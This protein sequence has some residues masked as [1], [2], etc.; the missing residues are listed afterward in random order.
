M[1]RA[2][3]RKSEA[4]FTLIELL[5]VIAII[6]ILAGMLL[7]A[8]A[9][10]KAKAQA[11]ACMNN[12]RQIG[13]A[14]IMYVGDNRQYPGCVAI[15]PTF[16]VWPLRLFSQMG[17]NRAVFYCPTAKWDAAWD[18][19]VNKTLGL[20]GDRFAI[21]E[22]SR[23]SLAYNDW[24]LGQSQISDKTK[25]QLGLG[26]DVNGNFFKGAVTEAMVVSPTEMIM[27]ADSKPDQ[28]WDGSMDP[29]EQGQ[30]PSNRHNR[31]T[32]IQ[33]ADGHAENVRR[34]DM[35]DPARDNHWRARWN[36]DN[37]LHNELTWAVDWKAEVKIDP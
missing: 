27:L 33:C 34:R 8:L 36:N 5:V 37:Q 2:P 23:F 1:R 7:P 3:A 21:R 11:T 22:D 28:S 35:V 18:T 15:S 20:P 19:N 26:G 9:K 4:A 10:A 12:L 13:L 32:N 29:T 14:T 25:A 31:R 24:G 6:A 16:Y 30:W 17:T